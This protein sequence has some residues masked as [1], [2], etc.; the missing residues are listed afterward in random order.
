[1]DEILCHL[2]CPIPPIITVASG[3]RFPPFTVACLKGISEVLSEHPAE[4]LLHGVV[5]D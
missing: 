5:G 1:M 2:I 4:G 3:A